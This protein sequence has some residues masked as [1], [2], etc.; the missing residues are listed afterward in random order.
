MR[1]PIL[2]SIGSKILPYRGIGTRIRRAI[3]F[4]NK[5]DFIN[6]IEGEIFRAVIYRES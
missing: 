3:K 2:T 5:I 4:Y 6:D 1:N